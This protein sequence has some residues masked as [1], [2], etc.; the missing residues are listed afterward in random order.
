MA[1]KHNMTPP[2]PADFSYDLQLDSYL[3]VPSDGRSRSAF[4][5][6]LL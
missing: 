6:A 1:M 2:L 3:Y 5:E 4:A